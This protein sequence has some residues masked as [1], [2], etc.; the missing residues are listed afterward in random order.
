[1][2]AATVAVVGTV[3]AAGASYYGAKKQNE[4]SKRAAKDAS[5]PRTSYTERT[6]YMNAY[7]SQIAP[8]ILESAQQ[9]YGNRMKGYGLPALDYSKVQA[10]IARQRVENPNYSGVGGQSGAGGGAG[11]LQAKQMPYVPENR[12]RFMNRDTGQ[13]EEYAVTGAN[14]RTRMR[15]FDEEASAPRAEM[16]RDSL[17]GSRGNIDMATNPNSGMS[18]GARVTGSMGQAAKNALPKWVRANRMYGPDGNASSAYGPGTYTVKGRRN[19]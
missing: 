9:V 19:R 8:Y 2:S 6:P 10:D 3:A 12:A 7:I 13:V 4:A 11:G 18:S 14:A 15:D 17:L 1:M 5:A 16:L